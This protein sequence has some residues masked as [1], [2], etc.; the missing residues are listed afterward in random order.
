MNRLFAGVVGA[1][2]VAAGLLLTVG[3]PGLATVG[4]AAVFGGVFVLLGVGLL[5]VAFT[6]EAEE[7]TAGVHVNKPR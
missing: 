4:L 3:P 1:V 6:R 7:G 5:Y 2:V